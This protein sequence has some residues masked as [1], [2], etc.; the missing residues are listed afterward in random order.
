MKRILVWHVEFLLVIAFTGCATPENSKTSQRKAAEEAARNKVLF[1]Y[2]DA[3][4]AMRSGRYADAKALLDDAIVTLGGIYGKDKNA[5]KARS[6]FSVEAKKTFIGEPY[7]RIMANYYRAILYWMDGEPDNARACFRTGQLEDSST[8][9][10]YSGDYVLLDYLDGLAT[11]KLGG[12]GSDAYNRAAKSCVNSGKP[13]PYDSQ[14]NALFFVEFGL[15]PSKIS[16]G[17]Y[18]EELRFRVPE[19]SLTSALLRINGQTIRLAPYDDLGFQATTRGGRVMDHVLANK[20]VFKTTT[21]AVG[22][23]AIVG[24]LL[25]AGASGDKTVQKAA[26]AVAAAG[27]VVEIFSMAT[28]P[29]ADIRA[30]DNLP[31]YLAFAALRLTPV[32]H[33]ATIEFLGKDGQPLPKLTKTIPVDV[34]EGAQDT[35]VFVSDR[36][37]DGQVPQFAETDPTKIAERVQT[38]AGNFDRAASQKDPAVFGTGISETLIF[39]AQ[40]DL[41]KAQQALVR[42]IGTT[43]G[44]RSR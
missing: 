43:N 6:N 44:S 21:A 24:G 39:R 18:R 31:R 40:T 13:P 38:A 32:Q 22:N 15:G 23:T 16:T 28:K 11:T 10:R 29:A 30:W 4:V 19:S 7:E 36:S 2:R 5:K 33:T 42:S 27:A 25:A 17:Q 34:R 41:A 35:V 20:A 8:E 37:N 1:Q 3:A 26:L 9:E 12:D 14:A